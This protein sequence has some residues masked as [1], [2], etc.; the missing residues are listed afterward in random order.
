MAFLQR[1]VSTSRLRLAPAVSLTF[2]R[3]SS[4]MAPKVRIHHP[5]SHQ[6][7]SL[8]DAILYFSSTTPRCLSRMSFTSTASGCPPSL[9]RRLLLTVR[10]NS[11]IDRSTNSPLTSH[12]QTPPLASSL[13]PV[14]NATQTTPTWPLRLPTMPL[15]ASRS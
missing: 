4:R 9:A 14:P 2:V 12:P 3:Y 11:T 6:L 10:T 13:E 1:A 15:P 5:S 8:T 7:C